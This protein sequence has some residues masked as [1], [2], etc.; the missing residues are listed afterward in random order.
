MIHLHSHSLETQTTHSNW[1]NAYHFGNSFIIWYGMAALQVVRPPTISNFLCL[2]APIIK[3]ILRKI[4]YLQAIICLL[5]KWHWYKKNI[6]CH[7]SWNE[8]WFFFP[9][10][11]KN[12]AAFTFEM[13]TT[14]KKRNKIKEF[15]RKWKIQEIC[16]VNFYFIWF[17]DASSIHWDFHFL[18][19]MIFSL[20]FFEQ[21]E[22]THFSNHTNTAVIVKCTVKLMRENNIIG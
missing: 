2:V 8:I 1:L 15:E 4:K 9:Q 18:L 5:Y 19:G 3:F 21:K 16:T 6:N 14:K 12:T 10:N 7:K 22:R 17:K 13:K 20:I 11:T